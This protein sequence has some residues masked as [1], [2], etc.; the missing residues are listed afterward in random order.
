MQMKS[1]PLRAA[2]RLGLAAVVVAC[3]GN[4]AHADVLVSNIDVPIRGVTDLS[5]SLW[6]SQ[7]FTT[8]GS[9]SVL[10]SIEVIAGAMT[11]NPT[12]AAE[13][14]ADTA[15]RP[16]PALAALSLA[17][18]GSGPVSLIAMSSSSPLPLVLSANT[19][20]WLQLGAT[21]A[22]GFGWAY[23][24]GNAQSGPG[25]LGHY[26]YSTDS[27][28]TWGAFGTDNPYSVRINVS[29]VPEP[30]S[31]ALWLLGLAAVAA[32]RR[33]FGGGNEGAPQ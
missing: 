6:A 4:A 20:Y 12:L 15:G 7:S 19:T 16:G 27:G 33:A 22:G 13:L 2:A 32:R 30:A 31:A 14:R 3:A 29:P 21:G 25:S 18:V 26:T 5:Q 1:L 24:E 9:D 17:G 23:A 11:G 28:A 8:D 10:M